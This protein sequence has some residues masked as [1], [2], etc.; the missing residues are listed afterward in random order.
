MWRFLL[1]ALSVLA[2]PAFSQ[3][4]QP[5]VY[6]GPARFCGYKFAVD[7][8]GDEHVEIQHGPDFT[9][10]G[11]VS[12]RGGFGLY[13]GFAPQYGT[14]DERVEAGLGRPTYRL[15]KR[16]NAFGYVIWTGDK[17]HPFYLHVWGMAFKGKA[18]D[19]RLLQRLQVGDASKRGC[20]KP[21]FEQERP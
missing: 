4:D 6:R 2:A 10:E 20:P 11:L 5:Q 7:L 14:G 16:D 21:T 9:L 15:A 17:P 8:Q 13:E 3:D 12:P 19:F 1:L 18:Q